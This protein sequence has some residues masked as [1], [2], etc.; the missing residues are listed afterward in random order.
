MNYISK[1][2]L[3]SLTLLVTFLPAI[4]AQQGNC[5]IG[6][7]TDIFGA[8]CVNS[9][10]TSI[11]FLRINPDGRSGAMGD[12]GIATTPDPSSIYYN[13]S[14]LAFAEDRA[15][16]GITYTPWLRQLVDD[17]FIGQITGYMKLD[18][19]QA[20]AGSFRYFNMGTINFTDVTGESLGDGYPQ[21]LAVDLGYTRKLSD[22]FSAG[23]TLKYFYSNLARGFTTDA[24]G[25][26]TAAN[27]VAADLSVFYNTDLSA[28][29][30]SANLGIGAAI[31]NIGNKV[32]YTEIDTKDFIPTNLG[33][34]AA[35]TLELD[36]YN[37]IMIAADINRLMVPTPDT[38]FAGGDPTVADHREKTLFS[39]MFGSFGDAPGGFTEEMREMMY[40]VGAEY[41]YN[42][43]FAVRA[44]Y[45]HEHARKGNRQ[46]LTLG[47]GLK[48]S[49]FGLNFSYLVPTARGTTANPLQNTLRF[50]LVFDLD[51][52]GK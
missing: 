27:G 19:L 11:P 47:L 35:Y 48:Y 52:N 14:K 25:Q 50:S 44:G 5:L 37:T 16:I 23:L 29:S 2:I 45:F 22:N 17:M 3:A 34:G 46:Y 13:A 10:F 26:I 40:S 51:D 42:Q 7:G 32:S 6:D 20:I 4:N 9:V 39:G 36:D 21:E 12:V 41:W 15:G 30:R 38:L 49:V 28:G 18:D 1:T 33:I 31:T 8:D 24:G 43:Q